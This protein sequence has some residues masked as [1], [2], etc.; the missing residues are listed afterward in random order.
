MPWESVGDVSTGE[1]PRDE[2]WIVTC[3]E[4]AADYLRF[5]VGEPDGYELGVMWHDHDLGSYPSLGVMWTNPAA[6]PPTDFLWRWEH[7]LRRFDG[8]IDWSALKPERIER[9]LETL[10]TQHGTLD[11]A[12]ED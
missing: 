5:V 6:G 2:A 12:D 10:R 1:M 3:L 11:E 7:A 4:W 8:S 9:E